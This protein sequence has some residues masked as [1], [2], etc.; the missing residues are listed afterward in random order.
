MITDGWIANLSDGAS[1]SEKWIE[2]TLSP[3]QR[4]KIHC[5]KQGLYITRLRLKI[6]G[7]PFFC[8]KDAPGYFQA[9]QI[10]NTI[11]GEGR[12]E[13]DEE[14]PREII[15]K[16]GFVARNSDVNYPEYLIFIDCFFESH[17]WRETKPWK[18]YQNSPA[19]IW[20]PGYP[21]VLLNLEKQIESR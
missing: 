20:V 2:G 9:H 18:E 6:N 7:E 12:F 17:H 10:P 13:I 15:R 4:L 11:L 1:V 16:V 19:I 3:W 8:L 5:E 14:N 21:D